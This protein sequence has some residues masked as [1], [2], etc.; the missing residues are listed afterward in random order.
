MNTLSA[1]T[2]FPLL[3][4]GTITSA[5]QTLAQTMQ[6]AWA[7]QYPGTPCPLACWTADHGAE[8]GTGINADASAATLPLTAALHTVYWLPTPPSA[9]A[10]D[11][12]LEQR[13]RTQ[14]MAYVQ[15]G[16]MLRLLYG[17]PQHQQTA[18]WE[19]LQTW[20][21]TN[22]SHRAAPDMTAAATPAGPDM[23]SPPRHGHAPGMR[24]RECLDP[25]S[26]RR[27]FSHLLAS[28]PPPSRL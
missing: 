6:A 9:P 3:L 24:C 19:C 17:L 22:A 2:T 7:R 10:Y 12:A 27:L 23:A 21:A 1:T 25:D 28:R 8:I 5:P 18:L 11:Q 16:G 15:A 4:A 20:Q 26:E 14:L 13:C